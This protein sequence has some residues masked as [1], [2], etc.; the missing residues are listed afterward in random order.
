MSQKKKILLIKKI[1]NNKVIKILKKNVNNKGNK[2]VGNNNNNIIKKNINNNGNKKIII[3]FNNLIKQNYKKNIKNNI[4]KKNN[5]KNVN[6]NIIKQNGNNNNKIKQEANNTIRKNGNN[7]T[8]RKII[9]INNK[10]IKNNVSNN[11]KIIK[12]NVIINNIINK[13]G[14]KQNLQKKTVS[15]IMKYIPIGED[16]YSTIYLKSKKL[17][18]FSTIFDWVVISPKSILELFKNDFKDFLLKDNLVVLRQ[19]KR[20]FKHVELEIMETKYNV[21]IP[22]HFNNID[23]DYN[24]IYDK[25]Q[26]RIQRLNNLLINEKEVTFVFKPTTDFKDFTE[27]ERKYFGKENMKKLESEMKKFFLKK[28]NIKVNFLYV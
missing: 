28:Y 5:N 18:K 22:H 9:F 4:I 1:V 16:C 24:M 2:N 10:I 3:I 20:H 17:R 25:F 12:K 14:N 15:T 27:I 6:N 11:N 23:N 26:K 21:F 13:N 19:S 7:N 8:I